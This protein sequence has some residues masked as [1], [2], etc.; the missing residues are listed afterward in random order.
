MC[1]KQVIQRLNNCATRNQQ[2]QQHKHE[3][4]AVLMLAFH[5]VVGD[6]HEGDSKMTSI[7]EIEGPLTYSYYTCC[8]TVSNGVLL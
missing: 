1:R 3:L 4:W 2:Q 6:A 7:C 8:S 5:D